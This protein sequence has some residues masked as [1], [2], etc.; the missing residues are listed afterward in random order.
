[1]ASDLRYKKSALGDFYI[2]ILE[3]RE[4]HGSCCLAGGMPHLNAPELCALDEFG[5]KRYCYVKVQPRNDYEVY[6]MIEAAWASEFRCVRYS[7]H[8]IEIIQRLADI[9]IADEVCDNPV[10]ENLSS[11]NL[12]NY[13]TIKVNADDN[14][15]PEDLAKS[16]RDY[17][18]RRR[19]ESS[20]ATELEWINKNSVTFSYSWTA[21]RP[22]PIFHKI[23]IQTW[24]SGFSDLLITHSLLAEQLGSISMS[25]TIDYFLR[26][27][28][29]FSNLQWYSA[30]EWHSGDPI[31]WRNTPY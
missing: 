30:S 6:K 28:G 24:Q 25:L 3:D 11:N 29:S 16:L 22:D 21:N 27:L 31:F 13:C 7:G 8:D 15:G 23:N 26:D 10:P 4:I 17:L 18:L 2:G 14:H 9:G 20:N 12:R 19:L 1:M 5:E